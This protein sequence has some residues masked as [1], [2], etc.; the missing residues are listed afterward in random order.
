AGLIIFMC[1]IIGYVG[2][3][4]ASHII[5]DGLKRLEYRGYDSVGIAVLRDGVI[6]LRKDEGMVE[7][8]SSAL[9]FTSL[10]G[11]IG[12]GHTRWAT[13]GAVCMEN[14]HPHSDCTGRIAI[15]HNGVIENFSALKRD[16]LEKGHKFASDTDS[17]VF[18][19]LLEENAKS[20]PLLQAFLKSV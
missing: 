11:H 19:H 2:S 12:I 3:G 18:A 14:A 5:T 9:E 20:L 1:G 15:A 13:H 4:R 6:S 17:E 7:E 8:V 16:L 10:D